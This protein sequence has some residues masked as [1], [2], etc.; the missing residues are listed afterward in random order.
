MSG[1]RSLRLLFL[2]SVFC[3]GLALAA[4]TA[5]ISALATRTQQKLNSPTVLW[6]AYPL[7][8]AHSSTTKPASNNKPISTGTSKVSTTSPTRTRTDRTETRPTVVHGS[9]TASRP[10]SGTGGFPTVFVM[11]GVIGAVLASTLLLVSHA[12]PARAG[13]YRR[14]RG[15]IKTKAPSRTG[16][17]GR[18]APARD[19]GRKPSRAKHPPTAPPAKVKHL[20]R[21]KPPRTQP[22]TPKQPIPTGRLSPVKPAAPRDR[23]VSPPKS[24]SVEQPSR[25][26]RASPPPPP[27][28]TSV[29]EKSAAPSPPD[30]RET[31][32]DLLEALRPKIKPVE[33]PERVSAPESELR[34]GKPVEADPHLSGVVRQA[35]PQRREVAGDQF[36]ELRLWRGYVK[37]Q[38]YVEVEGSPGALVESPLFRLR[39]PMVADDHAQKVLADLLADL[40]RSG[41]LVVEKG[42]VWYRRR[43]QRSTPPP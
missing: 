32:D 27:P 33:V 22:D 42:P 38:L 16:R 12:V 6:H 35:P 14:G 15:P 26:N 2:A 24:P 20:S 25:T 29:D 41:W 8:Q 19:T 3:A 34:P 9:G 13:G 11:A 43:L 37:C 30:Q 10:T 1:A 7:R 17:T 18:P 28:P 40:E 36:C 5:G 39:D 31:T 23:P 4:S 21:A